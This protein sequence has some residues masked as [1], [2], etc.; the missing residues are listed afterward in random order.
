MSRRLFSMA[1]VLGVSY[2]LLAADGDEFPAPKVFTFQSDGASLGKVLDELTKQTGVTIDRSQL[3]QERQLRLNCDK[4]PFWEAFQKIARESDHRISVADDGKK[5]QLQGGGDITYKESPHSIDRLF[6]V[7]VRKIESISDLE[8]DRSY[9]DVTLALHWESGLSIFLVESPGRSVT[10]KDNNEIDL[11]V[12]EDGGGRMTASGNGVEVQVRLTGI[13]R[14]A[15]NIRL[16][17]GKMGVVGA[18]KMTEFKFDKP[19][20]TKE[21][22]EE[23]NGDITVRFRCDFKEKSDLWSARVE[24]EY[25]GG[26]PQLES[27]ESS[28][29]LT[30]NQAWLQ[31]SDGK[32]KLEC[33]GGYEV[34]AQTDR[35][36]N[37]IY[38]FTD[39]T[40]IKMG[41]PEDWTFHV[42]TP[43]KLLNT[44][45]KFR[46]EN[47][48]LP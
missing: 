8:N 7:S 30:E 33:N 39:D 36:A 45:V 31:S 24:F 4:V 42:K 17:T 38:H 48:P 1:V 46:L 14:A 41:K 9:T 5:L 40:E 29:W 16:M 12:A 20:A 2:S 26:G 19:V 11:T 18:A 23:K 32:T 13:Q 44:E 43:A 25:P 15:K 28:A 34:L 27:F 47:I 37:V 3:E 10:A 6:R 21:A 35:K 22:R